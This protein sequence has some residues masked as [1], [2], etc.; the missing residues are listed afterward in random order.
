MI[1]L[2]SLIAFLV[3][4]ALWFVTLIVLVRTLIRKKRLTLDLIQS[5]IDAATL[6]EQIQKMADAQGNKAIEETDGFLRFLSESRDWAFQYIEDVQVA[7]EEYR[8]I[9]DVIPISKD[10][11]LQQ[12][13]QLSGAY[14]RLVAFLPEENLL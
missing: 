12:A 11:S 3:L 1:D 7:I 2:P 4:S 13:E 10:M 14:D 6:V 5:Q 8:Q 9:A